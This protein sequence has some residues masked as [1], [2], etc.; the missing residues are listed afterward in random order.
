[1]IQSVK[2]IIFDC[3]GTLVD[4]EQAH[5]SAWK[6]ALLDLDSDITMEEY[7]H[8]V[9]KPAAITAGLLATIKGKDPDLILEKKRKYYQELCREGLPPISSTIT[10]LKRL[11]NKKDTL[12]VKIGVCSAERKKELLSHLR[13]LGVIDLLDVVLSGEEDL[14]EYFDKEGVNKPKPYIYLHA[15][16][17]IGATPESTV[18]IEDSGPGVT[19]G[20]AAKCFTVAIPNPYTKHHNLSHANIKID[21][22]EGLSVE[23]FFAMIMPFFT[24]N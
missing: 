6:Q 20:I 16:K 17:M 21:S 22:F 23:D 10:F 12:G 13:H 3:D 2:A 9:G 5:Y 11:G 4:S 19:A 7:C 1:M 18:I 8:Y 24:Q 15:M 14:G